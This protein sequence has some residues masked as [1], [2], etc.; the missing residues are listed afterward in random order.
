MSQLNAPVEDAA[1]VN[2]ACVPSCAN[3][4]DKVTVRFA[5]MAAVK[6]CLH[7]LTRGKKVNVAEASTA[8]NET[9]TL[10]GFDI[11]CQADPM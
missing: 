7:L 3:E 1:R 5:V 11:V 2:L 9:P 10:F 4:D 6:T 8:I